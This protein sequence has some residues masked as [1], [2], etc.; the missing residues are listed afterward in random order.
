[1]SARTKLCVGWALVLALT[2]L[3]ATA[4]ASYIEEEF[5]DAPPARMPPDVRILPPP[6]PPPPPPPSAHV[7]ELARYLDHLDVRRALVYGRLAV[8]P[9]VLRRDNM[10]QGRWW[11]LDP[12]IAKGVLLVYER[13]GGGTVPLV[14]MENRSRNDYVF[15]MAGEVISGGKQTRTVRQDILLAPGQRIDVP[16]LCV[17]QH[18]WAGKAGFAPAQALVPQSIQKE[19]RK[20]AGQGAVWG[21]VARHNADLGTE[22]A[23]GS[24]EEGLKAAP[25][26]RELDAVRRTIVPEV[27]RDCV[28]FIFADRYA[29]RGL[30]AEFFGRSDLALALLPKLIDAY[31]V[32]F[33]VK[34]KGDRGPWTMPD[35][36]AAQFLSH[37][38]HAGSYRGETPGSGAGI[39]MRSAGLV[40]DG[41]SLGEAIV[42][43]GCQAEK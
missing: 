18:R 17:E 4:A 28:G 34:F 39:R 20:G 13:D 42:H 22:S 9:L 21:E 29:G 27:P 14:V 8:Y 24:L 31:A 2:V 23:T 33:V 1:V 35:S 32:D 7:P 38:R 41:V 26:R 16:V 11:T 19:M 10:L 37:I 15:V 12:A 36:V 40:G 5:K 3:A 43:F 6:P 30:G 25:V